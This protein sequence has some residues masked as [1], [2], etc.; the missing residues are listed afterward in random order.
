MLFGIQVLREAVENA[1][2]YMTKDKL[3]DKLAGQTS[4]PY[5]SL[6]IHSSAQNKMVKFV[7]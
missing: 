6:K 7:E 1:M 4:S 2:R 5:M 3:D